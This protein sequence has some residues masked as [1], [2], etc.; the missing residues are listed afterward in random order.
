MC[1]G[2]CGHRESTA[3]AAGGGIDA[4][5]GRCCAGGAVEQARL[6]EIGSYLKRLGDAEVFSGAVVIARDGKPVFA[7]AYG[8]AD[9]DKKIANTSTPLSPRQHEQ[10]I[11]GPRHRPTGRAG[12]AQLR[13]ST[14]E[15]HSRLSGRGKRQADQ[16][17]A[18]AEPHFGARPASTPLSRPPDRTVTV[19]TILD[20]FPKQP[21]KFEPGTQVVLQQHRDAASRPG[22]RGRHRP[23]LLRICAEER[24]SA[25]R[26][27]ERSVSRLRSR[28]RA[29][30]R[31]RTR[32][33]GTAPGSRWAN[34][35]A[36]TARRGGP[37][38]G[39]IASALDLIRLGQCDERGPHRKARDAST[40]CQRETRAC[41]DALRLR[42]RGAAR[43][44]KRPLVGHGG[45]APGQC[46]EFG[47]LTDT[48]YTIVVL[49]NVTMHTCM[50]V[51][52]EILRVLPPS[53]G[54]A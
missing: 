42:V 40:S 9:R 25:G 3:G 51:T 1:G 37:A 50:T 6:Q 45:N 24:L 33:S 32:S 54:P 2:A 47:A 23:G 27:D 31:S 11:H 8:Y 41:S 39:G 30:W 15:I 43:R 48:P 20:V 53:K 22:H 19:K 26:D 14:F 7:Q 35:M 29:R 4:S 18:S 38:G 16:D 10:A 28:R 12:E 52:G 21:L 34:Q 49:S 17:Q 13:R 44:A 36:N 46:T 5:G